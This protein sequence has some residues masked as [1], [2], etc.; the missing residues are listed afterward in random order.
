MLT[1]AC[2][3]DAMERMYIRTTPK[4]AA[5]NVS[6]LPTFSETDALEPGGNNHDFHIGLPA[7]PKSPCPILVSLPHPSLAPTPSQTT[8]QSTPAPTLAQTTLQTTPSPYQ[9]TPSQKKSQTTPSQ[10]TLQ[11]TPA[12]TPSQTT[13]QSTP[14]PNQMTLAPQ[15]I[16]APTPSQP[17]YT[18]DHTYDNTISD[19]ARRL[20]QRRSHFRL[21][22][23]LRRCKTRQHRCRCSRARCWPSPKSLRPLAPRE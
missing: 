10:T 16:L 21:H 11:S 3:H 15:T 9:T 2:E 1:C 12:P 4:R 7:P 5:S 23:R 8:P 20:H 19:Y 13:L 14:S 18:A 17:D 22:R 6:H